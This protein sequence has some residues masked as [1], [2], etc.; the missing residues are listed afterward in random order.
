[1][2]WTSDCLNELE[3]LKVILPQVSTS[4]LEFTQWALFGD[5]QQDQLTKEYIPLSLI[6]LCVLLE[7][8]SFMSKVQQ[9]GAYT[10]ECKS[11]FGQTS[12]LLTC[13]RPH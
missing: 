6:P 7:K 1:M 5:N 13:M 9:D 8:A 12:V 3:T 2:N 11:T 10:V 4:D